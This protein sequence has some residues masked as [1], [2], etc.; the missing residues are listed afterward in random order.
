MLE[1]KAPPRSNFKRIVSLVVL[2]VV[3]AALSSCDMLNIRFAPYGNETPELYNNIIDGDLDGKALDQRILNALY[4]EGFTETLGSE[5]ELAG[6]DGA[7]SARNYFR[8]SKYVWDSEKKPADAYAEGGESV[9]RV[10]VDGYLEQQTT[11]DPSELGRFFTI[12]RVEGTESYKIVFTIER[13]PDLSSLDR[14]ESTYYVAA[15]DWTPYSKSDLS[16]EAE[17]KWETERIY[18]NNG[19]IGDKLLIE[20]WEGEDAKGSFIAPDYGPF[21]PEELRLGVNA[22]YSIDINDKDILYGNGRNDLDYY[23]QRFWNENPQ[24]DQGSYSSF[25]RTLVF[26]EGTEDFTS[27]EAADKALSEQNNYYT[28]VGIS[29][30]PAVLNIP[31]GTPG[32]VKAGLTYYRRVSPDTE[33]LYMVNAQS[34]YEDKSGSFLMKDVKTLENY[35]DRDPD[36]YIYRHRQLYYDQATGELIYRE[37]VRKY[38]ANSPRELREGGIDGYFEDLET[39]MAYKNGSWDGL[40][41]IES[42]ETGGQRIFLNAFLR[43]GVLGYGFSF[44]NVDYIIDPETNGA[45]T[46][47]LPGG[48]SFAGRVLE[49]SGLLSGIYTSADGEEIEINP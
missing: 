2:L 16:E 24:R 35:R 22:I 39:R 44:N 17:G 23:F 27:N 46:F 30:Y 48:G 43:R 42:E 5:A 49:E 13:N 15:D 41:G 18:Y 38:H 37:M 26:P 1:K 10:P 40:I 8:P 34:I 33:R 4:P 31:E 28:E 12:E 3:I 20:T 11:P 36:L 32:K 9:V 19:L 6:A 21:D 47:D 14:V 7:A 29:T 25:T 45:V